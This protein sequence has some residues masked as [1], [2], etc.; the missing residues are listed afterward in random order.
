MTV[1][2]TQVI[3]CL[4]A[5]RRRSDELVRVIEALSA[6]EWDQ[7]TNCAPWRVH[8]LA[9]HL[10]TSGEGFLQ[11]IRRG[12]AGTVEPPPGRPERQAQLVTGG[13]RTVAAALAQVTTDFEAL[14]SG[15]SDEQLDTVCFHRRG[16]RSICWYAAHRLA[17]VA[18]HGWDLETSLGRAPRLDDG[19][20]RLLLPTLIESNVPR[21]YAAGLSQARGSGERY[22]LRVAD[23]PAAA[24]L[25]TIDADALHVSSGDAL[26]VSQV[27]APADVRVTASAAELAL[28]V[29][30]RAAL[31]TLAGV[32]GEPA[33]IGRFAEIFPR[34]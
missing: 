13:P 10:V 18:F 6:V 23:D 12:L 11:N 17:E 15:L 29:Y 34:P 14:Y 26:P 31:T 16:N 32:E 21:T 5:L 25:V 9:T 2:H 24:W 19:I 7:E 27:D 20:A 30:G 28:L 33:S 3:A 8:D 22:L 1:A 4:A